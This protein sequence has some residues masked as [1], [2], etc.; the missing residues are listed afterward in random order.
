MR[1]AM[2]HYPCD[3]EIPDEWWSEADMV[4]F[5]PTDVAYR[6][7]TLAAL[8][9]LTQIEP[10]PRL[11]ETKNDFHGLDRAR[12]IDVLKKIVRGDEIYPVP[13]FELRVFDE[14]TASPYLYRIRDGYHRFYGSI[15][16]GFSHLP[17]VIG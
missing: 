3:F 16:A 2:P 4:G 8:I 17:V 15:A 12:L 7:S 11:I 5:K 1:F 14:F 13:V 6:S 9:E 10:M